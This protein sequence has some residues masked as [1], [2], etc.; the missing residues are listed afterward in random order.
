MKPT[1]IRLQF[2]RR[3][4]PTRRRLSAAEVGRLFIAGLLASVAALM[5]PAPQ[6][7]AAADHTTAGGTS[8][9]T[10]GMAKLAAPRHLRNLNSELC[11][12]ARAG[13]GE[14]PVIQ[15]TCDFTRAS[16]GR[17]STGT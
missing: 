11:M 8:S 3:V 15:T 6:A 2:R 9:M 17:T 4:Q 1:A 12:T 13:S 5:V 7:T 16:P 10:A 14:R